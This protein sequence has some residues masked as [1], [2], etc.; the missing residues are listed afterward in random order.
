M[1]F[2][3]TPNTITYPELE[4]KLIAQ[5]PDYTFSMRGKQFLVARKSGAIGANIIIR[6]NKLN[7]VGNFPT[8][9]GSILF[10]LSLFLFGFLIP[11]IVYFAAFNGKMKKLEKEIG[12]YLQ[13]RYEK[14]I[15]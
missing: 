2:K 10:S 1:K 6:K 14:S 8:M 7:V 3:I 9:G 5:F 4:A 11:I 15:G 13:E 12:G